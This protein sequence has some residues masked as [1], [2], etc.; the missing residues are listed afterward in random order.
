MFCLF[1][2]EEEDE[3]LDEEEGDDDDDVAVSCWSNFLFAIICHVA[4]YYT[5]TS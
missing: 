2:G 1:L 5:I 3:E 4:G